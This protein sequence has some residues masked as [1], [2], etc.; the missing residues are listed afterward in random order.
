MLL[1]DEC[2]SYM[3][4]NRNLLRAIKMLRERAEGDEEVG[5]DTE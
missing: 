3:D 1:G 5:E 2:Q 4:D